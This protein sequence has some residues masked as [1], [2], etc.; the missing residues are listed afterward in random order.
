MIH[1]HD[2][3]LFLRRGEVK[4]MDKLC[5]DHKK[6]LATSFTNNRG[7]SKTDKTTTNIFHIYFEE[8]SP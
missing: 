3:N 4:H 2:Y 7:I 1:V 8:C 6:I 5:I